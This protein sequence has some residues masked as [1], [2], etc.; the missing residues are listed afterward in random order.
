VR[1]QEPVVG[2]PPQPVAGPPA[3]P[4]GVTLRRAR[5]GAV[6]TTGFLSLLGLL[7]ARNS[8]LFSLVA[9]ERGDYA[10][11]SILVEQAKH[12]QLLVG[13]YSRLGFSHP[14]PAFLYWQALGESVF[15][16]WLPVVP[17]RWD[18]Q[19]LA[20]L[21]LDS[22]LVALTLTI[23]GS[24]GRS[25]PRLALCAAAALLF[26]CAHGLLLSMPWMPYLYGPPF[27]LLLTAAASVA[28]GRA[29]HLWAL[30]LAGGLLVHGHAEFLLFVP[31]IAGYALVT[32]WHRNGRARPGTRRDWLLA[33]GV[34]AVF[35]LP[36]VLNLALHWP[37]ELGR[38][39][40]YGGSHHSHGAGATIT[41]VLRSWAGHPVTAAV[42]A[43]VLFG[44]AAVLAR[45]RTAS[46]EHRF[47]TAGLSVAALATVLYA[48]YVARA[49]DDLSQ[50]YVGYFFQAV[51]LFL[52][53]L[54]ALG[55]S[56]VPLPHVR[57]GARLASRPVVWCLAVVPLAAAFGVAARSPSLAYP[58]DDLPGVPGVA[59]TLADHAAG[60]PVLVDLDHSSWPVL[61]AL[62]V[63]G[64][65]TGR[66]VCARD[67]AW[68]FVVTSA[69]V[70]TDRDVTAG[71]SVLLSAQPAE[72][73]AV[74]ARLGAVTVSAERRSGERC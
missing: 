48:G 47:L 17:A 10:A 9:H 71:C 54:V 8:V 6:F 68:R 16:D 67:P 59:A 55:L 61:T 44:S 7:L 3:G 40:S 41:Y 28:A 39:L 62:I 18:A 19:W 31:V 42:L 70:C 57:L 66:R 20:L 24:W 74:L 21:V 14:G 37:G 13:N 35:L 45:L 46:P 53:L 36:I 2:T 49:V 51:P 56:G 43:V 34:V 63:E 11:N 64:D 50:D 1:V 22:A 58:G 25:W 32:S 73:A 60:R 26:L 27:L 69:F 52:V 29:A 4:P 38:Y 72:D 23:V 33:A 5:P 65:R 12:F 15:Y 30:A